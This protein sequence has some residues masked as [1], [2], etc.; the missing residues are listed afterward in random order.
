MGFEYQIKFE[1]RTAEELD[2]Q[3]R[4]VSEFSDFGGQ[5]GSYNFRTSTNKD[6]LPDA[7][8]RIEKEGIY[9]CVYGGS[10]SRILRDVIGL[11]LSEDDR[12]TVAKL[13]WQ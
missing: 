6:C 12:V 11:L 5:Y 10:G 9:F 1:R 4:S 2:A 8:A 7:E 3:P 13:D